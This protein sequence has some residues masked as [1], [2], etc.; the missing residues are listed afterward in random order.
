MINQTQ[1]GISVVLEDRNS[2]KG[3]NCALYALRK[4]VEHFIDQQI[5]IQEAQI[6]LVLPLV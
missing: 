6:F 5:E 2:I 3:I 4:K 1:F